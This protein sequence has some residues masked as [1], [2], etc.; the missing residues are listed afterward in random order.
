MLKT[1]F[2]YV[3]Y[4][5]LW[6]MKR[7]SCLIKREFLHLKFQVQLRNMSEPW[8]WNIQIQSRKKLYIT[9]K[10]QNNSTKMPLLLLIVPLPSSPRAYRDLTYRVVIFAI[11]GGRR[12]TGRIIR[13]YPARCHNPLNCS[14]TKLVCTSKSLITHVPCA[15]T[16]SK[17]PR[18]DRQRMSRDCII[19]NA[20]WGNKKV[21]GSLS[22]KKLRPRFSF[23][24][25]RGLSQSDRVKRVQ[26][27]IPALLIED[28][29]YLS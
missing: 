2:F 5:F 12:V 28:D 22:V 4:L 15:R 19:L 24:S 23:R 1:C 13:L 8:W 6:S 20:E 7:P 3:I 26:F 27:L 21:R 11:L 16:G 9:V 10:L 14:G 18:A 25:R 17:K 29:K